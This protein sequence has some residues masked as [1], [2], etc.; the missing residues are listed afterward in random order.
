VNWARSVLTNHFPDLW[1]FFLGGLFI[2]VVLAFPEG[3]VGLFRKLS[4][5]SRARL[6]RLRRPIVVHQGGGRY[7]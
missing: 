7:D 1:P 3:L 6:Y 5:G 4:S 2:A